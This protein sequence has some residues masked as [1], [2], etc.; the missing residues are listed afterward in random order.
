MF[1]LTGSLRSVKRAWC[2]R[3]SAV[4]KCSLALKLQFGFSFIFAITI[5]VFGICIFF[6]QERCICICIFVFYMSNQE[7]CMGSGWKLLAKPSPKLVDVLPRPGDRIINQN[8]E[9]RINNRVMGIIRMIMRIN[10][11]INQSYV[12]RDGDD[13]MEIMIAAYNFLLSCFDNDND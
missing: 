3:P 5:G 2:Y 13:C 10:N 12:Q 6:N 9:M 8:E 1:H 4:L 11:R 7:T